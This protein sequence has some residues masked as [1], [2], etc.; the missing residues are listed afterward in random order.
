MSRLARWALWLPVAAYALSVA[1]AI[2]L[3]KNVLEY[4]ENLVGRAYL[5]VYGVK[6]SPGEA[7]AQFLGRRFPATVRRYGG[8]LAVSISLLTN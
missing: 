5:T 4:L 2:S 8:Y 1:R 3:D 7:V 6:R